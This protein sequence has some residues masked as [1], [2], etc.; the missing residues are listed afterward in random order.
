MVAP[1]PS[2]AAARLLAPIGLAAAWAFAMWTQTAWAQWLTGLALCGAVAWLS[3]R[4]SS[5][6]ARMPAS[7]QPAVPV[8]LMDDATR[9]WRL[10]IQNVQ[11]QMRGSMDEMLNGFTS[12]L[13]QLDEITQD[14]KHSNGNQRAAMLAQCEADLRS[15]VRKSQTMA[16]SGDQVLATMKSLESVSSGLTS[17]AEE[18]GVLA[19]QTNLL[20]LNATIEAARAG[21]AGRGFAVVAAEV[22]RLSTASGDTGRRISEQVGSFGKQVHATIEQATRNVNSEQAAIRESEATIGGVIE[23]VE[24]SVEAL[25]ARAQDLAGRSEVVRQQVERLL[26]AFQFH[27]RVHQILDQIIRTMESAS[28]RL[29]AGAPPDKA[30]WEDL[31]KAGYT[32]AEQHQNHNGERAAQVQTSTATFF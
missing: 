10:H 4:P 28:E 21:D 25:N 3:G 8:Q 23:R 11:G 16:K 30:E 18:V 22:R 6:A 26:V 27:D 1:L 31:L 7:V 32:T 14:D 17:M 2:R 19:R 13:Q 12:I 29:K 9:L 20:S 5:A 24:S 15:L